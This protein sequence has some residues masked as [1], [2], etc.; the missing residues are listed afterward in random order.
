MKD[1]KIVLP[2]LIIFDLDDTILA[3]HAAIEPSMQASF[4]NCASIQPIADTAL[5]KRE[6]H[7]MAEWYWSD[8]DRHRIGRADLR[9]ARYQVITL[10]LKKLGIVDDKYANA[11]ATERAR[12]HEEYIESFPGAIDTIK[13]LKSSGYKLGMITNGA[14]LVQNAKIDRFMLRDYFDFILVEGEVGYGKP[15]E[16]IYRDALKIADVNAKNTWMVGDNLHFDIL[17]A[18]QLGIF[19]VWNDHKNEGLPADSN[20]IPDLIINSITEIPTILHTEG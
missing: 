8:L 13:H 5:L 20:I 17:A 11:L 12:L 19:T 1:N 4:A 3:Y 10:A 14:A 15:D 9:H 6:I 7:E 16:R 18:Q 2:Q